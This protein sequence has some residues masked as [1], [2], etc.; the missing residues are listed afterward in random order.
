MRILITGASSGLGKALALEAAQRFSGVSLGLVA[1]NPERLASVA[2]QAQALGAIVTTACIDVRDQPAIENFLYNFG[3]QPIDIA[4]VN[5]GISGG[6][7]G[8]IDLATMNRQSLDIF[9]VNLNGAL[10]SLHPLSEVMV[11]HG[12]GQIGVVGSMAGFLP[13]SSAPAYSASKAALRFYSLSLRPVLAQ[14]G[15]GITLI[16]PGF[17]KTPLTD[18]NNF[19]M[20]FLM[21]AEQAACCI[22]DGLAKNPAILAFPSPMHWLS[23]LASLQPDFMRHWLHKKLPAKPP[24]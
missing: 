15:V 1:R 18:R 22:Y 2:A 24:L 9:N 3:Q 6:S 10:Y 14:K 19:S 5:A 11:G 12:H 8:D 20:P 17:I 13:L 7:G 4:L 23:R 21:S 16:A